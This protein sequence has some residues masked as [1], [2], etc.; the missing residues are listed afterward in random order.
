MYTEDTIAAIT[1]PVGSGGVGIIRISGPEA[2][3]I[4]DKV[5]RFPKKGQSLRQQPSHTVHY[6]HVVD[7]NGE[8]LDEV[9]AVVMKGPRSYT[10]E[11]VL[12]LQCH[13]GIVPLQA[14]LGELFHQGARS[15]EP[16]EFTKRAFLNGR[17]DMSQAEAVMDVI[18][19]KSRAGL[20]AAVRQLDGRLSAYIERIREELVS[21]IARLEVTID[22]PEEDI[23]ELTMQEVDD[24]LIPIEE[25]L[26]ELLKKAKTGR[27][28]KD[29]IQ[30]VIAGRPN[31]G[32][33]SLLNALLQED[34][35]IV[36]DIPG[37]TRDSIEEYI[38]IQGVPVRLIDTA[39][40]REAEDKVE[41]IGVDKARQYMEDSDVV[42]LVIDASQPLAEEDTALLAAIQG[43][44][45]AVVL[46]KQDKERVLQKEELE[47]TYSCVC[48][49]VSAASGEGIDAV[50][51]FILSLVKEGSVSVESDILLT[52]LRHAGLVEESLQA[53]AQARE[54]IGAG[55][56]V[57]CV[58]VDIKKAWEQLGSVTGQ[59][60]QAD[61][62]SEIF[63]RFC[64]GK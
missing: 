16:G 48:L 18:T 61:I 59:T 20:S 21:L 44:P 55:M 52:N 39:G 4:G 40:I 8:V 30:T 23:E 62:I 6:G 9:L 27:M 31:A 37:T 1:T 26:R 41:Q 56:P 10:A 3:A 63:S 47:K 2:Y 42:L 54:T 22:Y 35:A 25:E 64:L 36:T 28:V 49:P 14:V 60:L 24:A 7:R 11:D 17:L 33:S 46:N 12:E 45:A 15:A 19:A 58:I 53:L 57:D 5:F 50:E 32:K 34:R 51:E 38:Q 13:G 29:G 43:R